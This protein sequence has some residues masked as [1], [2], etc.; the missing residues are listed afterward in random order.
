MNNQRSRRQKINRTR[1]HPHLL[2]IVTR[3]L[4]NNSNKITQAQFSKTN[5]QASLSSGGNFKVIFRAQET[6]TTRNL[7][8][9][10]IEKL[11]RDRDHLQLFRP[12][13]RT[14]THMSTQA[15]FNQ[16]IKEGQLKVC[17]WTCPKSEGTIAREEFFLPT[18]HQIISWWRIMIRTN[19]R[20]PSLRLDSSIVRTKMGLWVS[21]EPCKGTYWRMETSQWLGRAST[22]MVVPPR[23]MQRWTSSTSTRGLFTPTWP[24]VCSTSK[25]SEN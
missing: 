2:D 24:S 6:W 23:A 11:R 18:G 14:R 8:N 21:L 25:S 7:R 10:I 4:S 13:N 3:C 20:M 17:I 9:L 16:R 5:H 12:N 22:R 19:H 1:G 15:S